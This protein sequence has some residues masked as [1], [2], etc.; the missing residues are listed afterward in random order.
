MTPLATSILSFV[1]AH[2]GCSPDMVI[3]AHVGTG[4]PADCIVALDWLV[5]N[6]RLTTE[7]VKSVSRFRVKE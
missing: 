5:K 3:V 6:D 1:S 7:L 2:P 4:T